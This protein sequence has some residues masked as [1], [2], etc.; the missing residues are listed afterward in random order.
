MRSVGL[1]TN[2]LS[3]ND[4]LDAKTVTTSGFLL[5]KQF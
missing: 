1:G 3:L 2:T 5:L 4:I